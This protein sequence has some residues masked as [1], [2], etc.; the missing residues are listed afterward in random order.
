METTLWKMRQTFG[1]WLKQRRRGLHLTQ[2]ELAQEVG[3]AEVT[4]RKVEADELRPSR[5]L[6]QR[7]AEALQIPVAERTQFLRLARD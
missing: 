4:L 7:L 1:S 6:A 5:E 2:K 3:Y